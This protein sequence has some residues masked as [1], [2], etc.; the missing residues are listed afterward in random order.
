MLLHVCG[1]VC[2]ESEQSRVVVADAADLICSVLAID[3]YILGEVHFVYVDEGRSDAEFEHSL[4]ELLVSL[5]A[6]E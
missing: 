3:G 1:I 5:D 2:Q 4:V 6:F